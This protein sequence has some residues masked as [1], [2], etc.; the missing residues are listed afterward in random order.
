MKY[1]KGQ[2]L[3][4][5]W[6]NLSVKQKVCLVSILAILMIGI[7]SAYYFFGYSKTIGYVV[8]TDVGAF[9]IIQELSN[10]ELNLSEALNVSQILEIENPDGDITMIY[11]LETN[12]NSSDPECNESGD[13]EFLLHQDTYFL[14]EPGSS[15]VMEQGTNI[16]AFTLKAVNFRACPITSEATITFSE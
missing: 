4:G 13:Y 10:Q 11:T 8:S 14:I 6:K 7:G 9:T 15:F 12:I 5:R 2:K 16:F 1:D 3:K